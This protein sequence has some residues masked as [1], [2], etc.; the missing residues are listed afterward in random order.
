[1]FMTAVLQD[2][3]LSVTFEKHSQVTCIAEMGNELGK[4]HSRD[5]K[6]KSD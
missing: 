5:L 1:K 6:K 4:P 2:F 3:E